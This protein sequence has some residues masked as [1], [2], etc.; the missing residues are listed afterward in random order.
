MK[1][2]ALFLLI[3]ASAGALAQSAAPRQSLDLFESKVR[4]LLAARCAG[5][6]GAK[7]QSAGLRLDS[8]VMIQKG[9]KSGP[10]VLAGDPDSSLIVRA[11]RYDGK[12]KMP[13]TGKLW[14]GEIEHVVAWIKS[15]ASLPTQVSASVDA[16]GDLWSLKPVRSPAIP[17]VKNQAW[18]RNP[19]DA[20]VLAELEKRGLAPAPPAD[21]RTLI[22]RTTFD[23]LGV[24]PSPA[25]VATFLADKSSTA[26]DKLVDRLLADS[27][28]GEHWARHWLDVARFAESDG[29][30]YDRLRPQA[31][32]YRDYVI[33]SL[34]DD[35]PY[36]RFIVEQLAGDV[37]TSDPAIDLAE[38]AQLIAA[39]G[40]LMSGPWDQAGS[41]SA[42]LLL[43]M[44][45]RE[46]ELEE[47]IGTV[48][49]TFLG[50]TT[51]CARCHDHKFDP[52]PATDY[53]R[54]KAVFCGLQRGARNLFQGPTELG[55]LTELK[56]P[57][58][59]YAANSMQ[60]GPTHVLLRGDVEKKGEPVRAGGLSAIRSLSPELGLAQDAP[61]GQRRLK[62]A[63]WIADARNPLTARVM[64]NRV[65]HYHFGRGVVGTPNDFG[66]NGERPTHP[67]LLDWLAQH[68][69]YGSMG[70][71]EYGSNENVH[72]P[73]LPYPH[74]SSAWRLKPLHR[75]I[76]L[77]NAYRQ[78]GAYNDKAATLDTD[79]RYLWRFAPRR[80]EGESIRDAMLSVSGALN[81]A[82]GG[83]SF[84]PFTVSNFN[85]D[86]YNLIDSDD[87]DLNRR[88]V[89]RMNVHSAK[90]P[91]LESLDCP[92]P[93]AK[94]PRRT[95]T[96]TPPQALQLMN[97]PF[98]LRQTRRFADRVRT[99]SGS[100]VA[101]QVLLAHQLALGRPPTP[102]ESA[103]AIGLVQSHGLQSLCWS[104]FNST[105][106]LYL[107]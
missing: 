11:L 71:W 40:F 63:E 8:P 26:Y 64:V 21:R 30:E 69:M 29:F 14:A 39:T 92:D 107:R 82:Q 47:I 43:R 93:A 37:I 10:I 85:S 68:F 86:F 105:E 79:D 61:E 65:W 19:I 13:P 18:V 88:S 54:L 20:F 25:E 106:F 50:M 89:Y 75:L 101:D 98:V 38:R 91:L 1:P 28:Y 103:R 49:Q 66:A 70:V 80:L 74:T 96:T 73:I 76:M 100:S 12:V 84:R 62:L 24:P 78:S 33:K 22:R 2:N 60:P 45:I 32:P 16:K 77:S 67:A 5:C 36:S 15:G 35:K 46:E 3:G 42:S 95:V 102:V 104:L 48:G 27:R 81:T 83:P 90:D 56:L 87:P 53:Y 58:Q 72:T 7:Q 9:S 17:R 4:P 99:E 51:N 44:R 94:T 34:N 41:G 6:H 31:W 59:A 52:I 23:L 97:N 55:R 57:T